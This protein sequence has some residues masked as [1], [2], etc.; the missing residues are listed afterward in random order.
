[1]TMG[2]TTPANTAGSL[3]SSLG[4]RLLIYILLFSSCVTLILTG[5]QLYLDFRRDVAGIHKRLDEIERS[6]LPSLAASLWNMDEPLLRAQMRGILSLPGMHAVEVRETV[7]NV[8]TPLRIRLETPNRDPAITRDFGIVHASADGP[9]E[10]GL[11]RLEASLAPL[12]RELIDRAMVILASQGVKTFL[13][14]L[15]I[16]LLVH[17]LV[18]RHLT[19]LSHRL[20]ESDAETGPIALHLDRAPAVGGGDELDHLV[21]SINAMRARL[22]QSLHDLREAHT[23]MEADVAA[24]ERAEAMAAHL[25]VHDPLTDLPN[26]HQLLERMRHELALASRLGTHGAVILIDLDHFK[27]L[28]DALG[29]GIGDHLL[30]SAAGRLRAQARDIDLVARLGGDEFAVLLPGQWH[31][32]EEATAAALDFAERLR[33]LLS[34]PYPT[35]GQSRHLAASLGVALYPGDAGDSETLLKHADT[36]LHHAKSEGRD[37]VRLFLPSMQTAAQVRHH[38]D[39]WLREALHDNQ[40]SLAFQPLVDGNGRPYGA[41]VLLRWRHPEQGWIAPADF[42]PLAEESGLILGIGQ[43]VLDAALRQAAA[44]EN[45]G[46]SGPD[47]HLA[48]NVSP[49]QFHHPGFPD[50]VRESL[51][52]SGVAPTRL[53]MEITEGVLLQHGSR[54]IVTMR[55]LKDLGVRFLIDDFGTGYSSLSYLKRL[56][57]DGVKI[58]QS[59]VADLAHDASDAAIVDAI[60]GVARG[61]DLTV[62]AEGVETTHQLEALRRRGC[63][64]YQG[65]LFGHPVPTEEFAR[66]W[67]AGPADADQS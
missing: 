6:H 39:H 5:L 29:H 60:L 57:V 40:F 15:F 1:M 42:I 48:V 26:R 64:G 51:T 63:D 66:R 4:R 7:P 56:P 59:F 10:I 20:G 14:S 21:S 9:R 2:A 46:L 47:F 31:G 41:E 30:A 54:A 22:T 12:Y 27:V 28:N 34:E 23:R 11:L 33:L 16:L 3:K 25:A 58:D 32:R 17:R 43:W 49:R 8:A 45:A 35:Q 61:F 52:R 44:W 67:L 24:R 18:T 62:V 55:T 13:V 36:A 65:Y 37:C 38:L 53:V 19:A 50:R